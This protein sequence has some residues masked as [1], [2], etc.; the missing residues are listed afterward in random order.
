MIFSDYLPHLILYEPLR[1]FEGG[2][3][4]KVTNSIQR[5]GVSKDKPEELLTSSIVRGRFG[6]LIAEHL[7]LIEWQSDLFLTG[8]FSMIDALLE[9]PMEEIL[10][11]LPFSEQVRDAL[12]GKAGDLRNILNLIISYERGNW[13]EIKHHISVLGLKETDL[14]R[15]HRQSL[16]WAYNL[17]G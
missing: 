6:E 4:K 8:L 9:K 5:R 7:G 2:F 17:L 15:L 16:A 1:L 12:Q 3:S 14:P 13:E 11:E 10:K